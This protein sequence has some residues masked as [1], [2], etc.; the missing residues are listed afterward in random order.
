MTGPLIQTVILFYFNLNKNLDWEVVR[1]KLRVT[2]GLQISRCDQSIIYTLH[3]I[4]IHTVQ[5]AD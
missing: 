1:I 5:T 4:Y 3:Y 2:Y